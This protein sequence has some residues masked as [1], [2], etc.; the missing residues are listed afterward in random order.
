M[1]RELWGTES[2]EFGTV[3]DA[4][5]I[6]VPGDFSSAVTLVVNVSATSWTPSAD[7]SLDWFVS[8][9]VDGEHWWNIED[10][11][12]IFKGRLGALGNYGATQQTRTQQTR[13]FVV[14]IGPRLFI[15]VSLDDWSRS[16]EPRAV[17]FVGVIATVFWRGM[18]AS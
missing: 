14:P 17:S 5:S 3:R 4:R 15:G 11:L 18:G 10:S 7:L 9:S 8:D 13:R 1:P 6:T 12:G 2:I 16:S